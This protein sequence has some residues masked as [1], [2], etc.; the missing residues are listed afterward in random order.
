MEL[1]F[2]ANINLY[3]SFIG[4]TFNSAVNLQSEKGDIF[5]SKLKVGA[6]NQN[7]FNSL[8]YIE[9]PVGTPVSNTFNSSVTIFSPLKGNYFNSILELKKG[10][11]LVL[12]LEFSVFEQLFIPAQAQMTSLS[13]TS[14]L[15][16]SKIGGV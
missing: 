1:R 11:Y 3:S 7:T 15:P 4:N 14:E 10:L 12:P 13:D 2:N 6:L 8:Q 9:S 16:F 5:N